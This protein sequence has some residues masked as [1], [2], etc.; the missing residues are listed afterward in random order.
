MA[1]EKAEE[2]TNQIRLSNEKYVKNVLKVSDYN[3]NKRSNFSQSSRKSG[4]YN[5]QADK[6]VSSFTRPKGD[7]EKKPAD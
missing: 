6:F 3:S 5:K 7:A 4:E 2:V 1:E